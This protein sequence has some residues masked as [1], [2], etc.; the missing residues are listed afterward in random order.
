MSYQRVV[1]SRYGGP[2]VLQVEVKNQLPLPQNGEVRVRMLSTSA[3]FTDTLIRR[4]IYYGIKQKPPFTPGYDLVGVVDALGSG[5]TEI[6]V[7]QQVAALTVTGAYSEFLCLPA[8]S[9][10]PVPAG[11]DPGEAVSLVLTYV[12]AYQMLHRLAK[13]RPGQRVLIHGASG[14]VGSALVQLGRLLELELYGTVS[15]ENCEMVSGMGAVP[16]DYLKVDFV[17]RLAKFA[18]SGVDAVFDGIGGSN[19]KRS[20]RCLKDGGRLIAYGSL[21]SMTG[22]E[23]G[24]MLAYPD[25]MLRNFLSK[26]KSAS[27]YSIVPLKQ[28]HPDWFRVD[29][30]ELFHML[31]EGKIK[32]V[33]SKKFKM[34]EAAEAH[35]LLE[36]RGVRGKIVLLA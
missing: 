27:I 14:A 12:T 6:K 29:L 1:I 16:I 20:F 30:T 22:K 26:G 35:R 8:A 13:V 15:G 11:L 34:T 4:G 5:V 21:N 24:G 36:G 3:S 18:P 23:R 33:I 32:P 31:E 7:G 2:E 9:C 25:L 19:F 28:K 17:A 10:V